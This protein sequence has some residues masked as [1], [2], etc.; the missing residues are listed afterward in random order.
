MK[1]AGLE[2]MFLHAHQLSFVWPDTGVEFSASAPLPADLAAVIDALARAEAA[3]PP[4]RVRQLVRVQEAA[5]ARA[6][7]PA[8]SA[9]SR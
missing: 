8:R 5:R 4:K 3:T 9:A 6:R 1:S 2:R 7:R